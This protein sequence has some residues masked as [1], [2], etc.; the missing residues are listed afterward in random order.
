MIPWLLVGGALIYLSP[1][2]IHTILHSE[3]TAKWMGSLDRSGYYPNLAIAV[4]GVMTAI[5]TGM[6]LLGQRLADNPSQDASST[7]G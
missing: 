6:A 4:A 7:E 3:M 2:L 5:G 1:A